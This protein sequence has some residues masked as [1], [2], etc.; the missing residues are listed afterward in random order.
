MAEPGNKPIKTRQQ[1]EGRSTAELFNDLRSCVDALEKAIDK[2]RNRDRASTL[3]TDGF[4]AYQEIAERFAVVGPEFDSRPPAPEEEEEQMEMEMATPV[5]LAELMSISAVEEKELD[6]MMRKRVKDFRL[7]YETIERVKLIH[8]RQLLEFFVRG[9]RQVSD[10]TRKVVAIV[11]R[12][13]TGLLKDLGMSQ[14]EVS[15]KFNERRATTSA[16]EKRHVE[17]LLHK[18]GTKGYLLRGGVK[19]DTHRRNCRKSA[20]GNTNRADAEKRKKGIEG[21][22]DQVKAGRGKRRKP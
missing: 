12:V 20:M 1:G 19:S 17:A 16:R 11:R 9:C 8:F 15:R 3:L 22:Q 13:D 6:L 4:V 2:R 21:E 7:E 18:N 14:V 5:S 10:V